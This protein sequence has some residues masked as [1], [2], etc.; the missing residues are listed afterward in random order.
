[1]RRIISIIIQLLF[2][3]VLY[4][5]DVQFKAA[6][7]LVVENGEQFRLT[8][9]IN[10]QISSFSAPK[11]DNFNFLGGPT[12]SQS[13]SYNMIN[14]KMSQT[15]E[16]SYTYYFQ[17]IK[18][19]KF[20]I[21]PAQASIGG[22]VYSSNAVQIEVVKGGKPVPKTNTPSDKP[23]STPQ[24]ALPDDFNNEDLFLRVMVDK[25]T[26]F[27]GEAI[28]ATVKIFS[29]VNLAQVGNAVPPSF[30]GFF[31]NDMETQPLNALVRENVNGQIYSTGVLQRFVLY[32]Q[33]SGEIAIEPY[34]ID[35]IVQ[36]VAR[37]RN[38]SLLDDFFGPSVQNVKRTISSKSFK[39]IV[40]PLPENKPAGFSG[41]VG[42]F[43]MKVNADKSLL[44]ENDAL[45]LK[46]EISGTGNIKLVE[47]PRLNFPPDFEAYDPKVTSNISASGN[48]GNKV[49]EYLAIPRHSGKFRIPPVE[50]AYFNPSTGS[51]KSVTSS[52]FN[53]NVNKADESQTANVVSGLSKEDVKFIGNDIRFIKTG[54]IILLPIGKSLAGST[55]FYLY[56]PILFILFLSLTWLRRKQIRENA[57]LA[58]IRNR[59]ASK[60]AKKRLKTAEVHLHSNQRGP[61]YDELLNALYGYLS[62]KLRI[63]MA[64]LSIEKAT[65]QLQIKRTDESLVRSITALID[66]CQYARYAPS[67]EEGTLN[68]DY[69]AAAEIIGKL[70]QTLR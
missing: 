53:I 40:K 12:Q 38:G 47:S 19:G 65:E 3:Q 55:L 34:K 45:T 26:A 2:I 27:F 61:F 56:F 54:K 20:T 35:C 68:E 59:K 14:G 23:G 8:Y 64:E 5:Q 24:Q 67:G 31:K 58:L 9:T 4:S 1:M 46:I 13:S 43:S 42:D 49:F 51:Y 28:T 60:I 48:S 22:K 30:A 16:L 44:K 63:S 62:D 52:D 7:P 21:Q 11:F 18:E 66:R 36:Q 37:N 6:A 50:F 10:Q 39:I 29:R 25:K 33:K 17:A 41:A 70:E 69:E 57:D 32:P 15:F